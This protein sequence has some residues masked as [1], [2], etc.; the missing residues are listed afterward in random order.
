MYT[1][2]VESVPI[3]EAADGV[4]TDDILKVSRH[5]EAFFVKK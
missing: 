5:F 2:T 1:A 4:L 3:G